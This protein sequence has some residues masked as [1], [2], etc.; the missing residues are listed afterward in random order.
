M[1]NS[2]KCCGAA[3]VYNI[4][5][6]ELSSQLLDSKMRDVT[7][8]DADVVTTANPGCMLQLDLGLRK[9][10]KTDRSYHV[11]ELLD[12]AYRQEDES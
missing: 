7:A 5:N 12:E 3:G 8:A 4:V 1:Q 10:G 11:V 6:P 9:Q 2:D